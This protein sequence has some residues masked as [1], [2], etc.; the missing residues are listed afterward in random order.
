MENETIIE[1]AVDAF[2]K[3]FS[4]RAIEGDQAQLT[5][6]IPVPDPAWTSPGIRLLYKDPDLHELLVK[7][8]GDDG[9][10]I[11][12]LDPSGASL[13]HKVERGYAS[14]D[15]PNDAIEDLRSRIEAVAQSAGLSP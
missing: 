11:E 9:T 6:K 14:A 13:A 4:R 3:G 7:P 12:A 15:K 2:C 5:P 8:V 10:D 1:Q